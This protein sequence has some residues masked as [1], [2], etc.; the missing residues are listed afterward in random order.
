MYIY[1]H[2]HIYIY[3]IVYIYIYICASARLSIHPSIHATSHPSIQPYRGDLSETVQNPKQTPALPRRIGQSHT[4][5][6]K[7]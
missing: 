7:D 4:T 2:T 5:L 1:T 3:Y 6:K